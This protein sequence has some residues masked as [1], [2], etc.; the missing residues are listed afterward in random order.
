[1]H[2]EVH[3]LPGLDASGLERR[4]SLVV[5]PVRVLAVASHEPHVE[6]VGVADVP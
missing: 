6:G 3:M 2:D 1:M 5:L 4:P